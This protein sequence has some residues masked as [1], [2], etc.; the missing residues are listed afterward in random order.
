M[1]KTQYYRLDHGSSAV[2]SLDAATTEDDAISEQNEVEE[3]D[4]EEEGI[5]EELTAAEIVQAGV[6]HGRIE[7]DNVPIDHGELDEAEE[8]LIH[9]FAQGGCHCTFGSNQSACC[10]IITADHYQSI[11]C[12]MLELTHDELDL[13][14]MGQVMAGCFSGGTLCSSWTGTRQNLHGVLSQWHTDLQEDLSLPP[15]HE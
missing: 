1:T 5:R 14:V 10:S 7:L 9:R 3:Q 13:V 4:S 2:E 6:T 12:Q 15:L 8:L 11:R